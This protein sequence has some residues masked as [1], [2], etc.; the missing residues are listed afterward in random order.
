MESNTHAEP[1]HATRLAPLVLE[2]L[3]QLLLHLDAHIA[4]LVHFPLRAVEDGTG[5]IEALRRLTPPSEYTQGWMVQPGCEEW[6]IEA[7]I[8]ISCLKLLHV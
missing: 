8:Y 3:L 6:C 7:L 1:R 4:F 2:R 5:R